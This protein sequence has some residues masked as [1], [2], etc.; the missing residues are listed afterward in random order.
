MARKVENTKLWR[1]C[2][3]PTVGRCRVSGWDSSARHHK[4]TMV[5]LV[6]AQSLVFT[7]LQNDQQQ[8][9]FEEIIKPHGH[10][11]VIPCWIISCY[12]T[13]YILLQTQWENLASLRNLR[14]GLRRSSRTCLKIKGDWYYPSKPTRRQRPKAVGGASEHKIFLRGVHFLPEIG[15]KKIT[16]LCWV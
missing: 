8:T 7:K 15:H 6:M 5:E 11:H 4:D 14:T 10:F 16:L 13:K 9:F 12:F 2:G 1:A 3:L